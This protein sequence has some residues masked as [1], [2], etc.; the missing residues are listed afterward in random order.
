MSSRYI[1]NKNQDKAN[2]GKIYPPKYVDK[3]PTLH[4][5]RLPEITE[6]VQWHLVWDNLTLHPGYRTGTPRL[7]RM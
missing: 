3:L 1:N 2:K 4:S 6:K 7:E 5:T